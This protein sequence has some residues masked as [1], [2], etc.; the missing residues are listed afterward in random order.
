MND[1]QK[2]P[3]FLPGL[4]LAEGFDHEEVKP[5]L[6]AGFPGL[7]YSAALIGPGSEVLGNDSE[8]STDH[9]WGPR[10]M[11]FLNPDDFVSQKDAIR[12]V[13]S[14]KLPV[15]YK[16]YST[17]FAEPDPEDNGTQ[18]P[19]PITSGPVNHRIETLTVAGFFYDYLGIDVDKELE[20]IDW[21]TLPH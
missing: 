13:L 21:F 2:R 15:R 1:Q 18:V 12:I 14:N 3:P 4:T 10:V 11:L 16:G 6:E 20:P 7:R 5:I 17:N 19:H 8:M 9:H